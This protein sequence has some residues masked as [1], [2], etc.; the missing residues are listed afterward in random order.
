MQLRDVRELYF[1]LIEVPEHTHLSSKYVPIDWTFSKNYSLKLL[2][3]RQH[4]GPVIGKLLARVAPVGESSV[5]C[6]KELYC[7]SSLCRQQ[8]K[9]RSLD[10]FIYVPLLYS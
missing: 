8:L 7:F 6:L 9:I 2:S 1:L 5:R 4:A 3:N 10:G